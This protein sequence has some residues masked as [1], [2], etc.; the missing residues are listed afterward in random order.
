MVIT[1]DSL[2][3]PDEVFDAGLKLPLG[4]FFFL[5]M[6]VGLHLVKFY[7]FTRVQYVMEI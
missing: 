4:M 1:K 6:V 7:A 5:S 3:I 2:S